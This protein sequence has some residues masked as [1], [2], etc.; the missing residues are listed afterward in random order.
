MATGSV[1]SRTF[2]LV[3]GI[4]DI[5]FLSLYICKRYGFG[6]VRLSSAPKPTRFTIERY[7][8][9]TRS[10]E[11]ILMDEIYICAC[12]GHTNFASAYKETIA[13]IFLESNSKVKSRL[14]T[15]EDHD[16]QESEDVST[17]C[18]IPLRFLE[19]PKF[20]DESVPF[21]H[22]TGSFGTEV[23]YKAFHVQIPSDQFGCLETVVMN[24][25]KEKDE[26]IVDESCAFVDGL[27]EEAARHISHRRKKFKAKMGTVFVL[28]NPDHTFDE[29]KERFDAIDCDSKTIRDQYGFLAFLD[30]ARN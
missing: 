27:S 29:I 11:P 3:E 4:T 25:I 6:Y 9:K 17:A 7:I 14:I 26:A 5:A 15:I 19:K 20:L 2:I 12:D 16:D 8:R 22:V 18:D 10:A 24:A 30:D 21:N 13:P 28:L 23:H 1:R